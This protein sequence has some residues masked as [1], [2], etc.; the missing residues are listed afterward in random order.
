MK[1][2]FFKA[3]LAVA[4]A[5]TLMACSHEK[6]N[7]AAQGAAAPETESAQQTK[8]ENMNKLTLPAE[9]DK[10][11][12]KSDKVEHSKVTFKNHFGIEL[13]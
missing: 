1:S 4:S 13:A 3:A 12:P 5:C 2:R 6:E 8:E 11:F 9:W 7:N 10:V